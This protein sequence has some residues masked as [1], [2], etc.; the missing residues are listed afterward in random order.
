MPLTCLSSIAL[1]L[2]LLLHALE[3]P[4]GLC[5][6]RACGSTPTGRPTL[7][8]G[9]HWT[10][11]GGWCLPRVTRMAETARSPR[12]C[13]KRTHQMGRGRADPPQALPRTRGPVAVAAVYWFCNACPR[14]ACWAQVGTRAV[15]LVAW[16]VAWRIGCHV[17]CR[18]ACRVAC[19]VEC[20][21]GWLVARRVAW[22]DVCRAPWVF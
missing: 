18:V 6:R 14:P 2:L 3:N 22:C 10:A 9:W 5:G 1:L 19:R 13:P 17:V 15:W 11:S 16:R 7:T 4:H 21:A 12:T 8:D 20:R